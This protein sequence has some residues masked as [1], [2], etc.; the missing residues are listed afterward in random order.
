MPS[1]S[2]KRLLPLIGAFTENDRKGSILLLTSFCLIGFLAAVA[3]SVDVGYIQVQRSRMQNAVDAAALAAGQEITRAVRSAPIGTED[4]LAYALGEARQVASHVAKLSGV[5]VNPETDVYFGQRQFDVA[6][7]T[8]ST[9]WGT[10]VANCVRVVARRNQENSAAQDGKLRLFFGGVIGTRFASVQ[11]EATAYV[12]ARDI[13]VVHDFSRSMNFDSFFSG[14]TNGLSDAKIEENLGRLWAD[15]QPT[16]TGKLT[17]QPKHAEFSNTSNSTTV[18]CKFMYDQVQV[19]STTGINSVLL[20]YSNNST[21]TFSYNGNSK[22]LTVAGTRDISKVAVT[23]KRTSGN[24]TVT[25]NF[26]DSDAN[27]K[28]LFG[29]GNYPFPDG[30][31]GDYFSHCRSST[32][33][34]NRNYREMYGGLTFCNFILDQKSSHQQTPRI[35]KSRHYPFTSIK[36]GHSLLC[37]FLQTLSFDDRIGMVSYDSNHRIEDYQNNSSDPTIPVVDIRNEP[38]SND[39]NAV[40]NL[41][42]YK[43]ANHYS[44]STNMGGG[45]KSAITL[46]DNHSRRTSVPTILLMTD[47]N[48]NAIDKGGVTTL[49]R[50]WDWDKLF[51]YDGDG[52]SD[53][54]TS[55]SQ[56]RHVLIQAYNAVQKGYIV[57][58]MAVGASADRDLLKAIAWL[59]SGEF[60]NVPGGTSTE[61]MEAQLLVAFQKIASM[62]PPAKL[63]NLEE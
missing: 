7:Q 60:I 26:A 22:Q 58:T 46:L 43:Q 53:Y 54:S 14:E 44:A 30:S 41:M 16:N 32:E 47:G 51:D 2:K 50:G 38:I 17:F 5:Y 9:S 28:T 63:L 3:L 57:N 21:K 24:Q 20:T 42:K 36:T 48:S 31:W 49:P 23:V 10:G 56:R 59:G 12:Q 39:Y 33:L 29:L 35:A 13:I 55:D 8:W 27:L 15:L 61:E 6:S 62:V 1:R 34:S 37:N 40:N 18:T 11:T 52:K 19:T 45:L 4:P 25:H